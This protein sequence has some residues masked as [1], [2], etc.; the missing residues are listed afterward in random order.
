MAMIFNNKTMSADAKLSLLKTILTQFEKLQNDIGLPSN[1]NFTTGA[2]EPAV[3]KVKT[4]TAVNKTS[5]PTENEDT[6]DQEES[7]ETDDDRQSEKEEINLMINPPPC[8]LNSWEFTN[9]TNPK[10]ARYCSKLSN[11]LHFEA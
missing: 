6:N 9:N 10:R 7:G 3:T 11:T 5:E 4:D 1:G 8:L 2:S